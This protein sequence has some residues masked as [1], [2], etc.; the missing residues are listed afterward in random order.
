MDIHI[1]GGGNRPYT[2][3][4]DGGRPSHRRLNP[5]GNTSRSLSST[6]LALLSAGKA[7]PFA[8]R[9]AAG[10]QLLP[11]A[12]SDASFG[13]AAAAQSRR[14]LPAGLPQGH[15]QGWSTRRLSRF[16][17]PCDALREK[18]TGSRWLKREQ[19]DKRCTKRACECAA[20]SAE[21][22]DYKQAAV[23]GVGGGAHAAT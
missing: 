11:P 4:S 15:L 22:D 20:V 5:Q 9:I 10:P 18:A 2:S 13:H 6:S 14:V 7:T 19:S 12:L 8:R 1:L 3:R 21:R 23:R 17:Q 16:L